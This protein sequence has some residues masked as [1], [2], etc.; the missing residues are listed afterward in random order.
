MTTRVVVAGTGYWAQTALIP[1][2]VA[3]TD[4]E[5][6]AL[7]DPDSAAAAAAGAPLPSAALR[8][9][10]DEAFDR[11]GPIDLV[12][13]GAPD[14]DHFTLA[15]RA[16]EY[17]AAVYCEKPLANDALTAGHLAAM[18]LTARRPASV[19]YSFRYSPAIQALKQDIKSGRIGIPWLIELA[20]HNPQFHPLAGKP[21]NWKGDPASAGAGAL[22]EYG[23]HVVDLALWLVGPI[24]RISSSLSRVLPGARLDDIAT[25][26]FAFDAPVT[27]VL[28]ASWVLAGGFPGIRIRV[29]GSE[30][31]AQVRLDH[32]IPNGQS[33]RVGSPLAATLDEIQLEPLRDP[34]NDATRRHMADL[35]A[36]IAEHSPKHEQT[37][38]TFEDGARA[39][40]VLEA[41]LMSQEKWVEVAYAPMKADNLKDCGGRE[42]HK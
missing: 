19:G 31:V 3:S 33:Y 24:R 26:L 15:A 13:V 22:Y 23:S 42:A 11:D 17:G 38:P 1:S 28:I 18:S 27:G 34:R 10:L 14:R 40:A 12:V 5:I 36:L 21:L 32:Q 6:V 37:L 2:L 29:H 16:L 39:Q 7:I 8:L 41:S 4:A 9:S 20:E 25:L 35:I 30:G